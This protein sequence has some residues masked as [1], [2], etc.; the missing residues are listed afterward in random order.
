LADI[1]ISFPLL[2]D[3]VINPP[4]YFSVFGFKVYWYGVLLAAAII[5]AFIYCVKNAHK[6]GLTS[7][8]LFDML[9]ICVPTAVIGCRVYYVVFN[10]SLYQDNFWDIFKLRDGGIAMYG[11]IIFAAIALYIYSRFK[12]IPFGAVLDSVAVG[13]LIGHS[14]GRWGNFMNREAYGTVTDLPWK[15]GL[16]VNGTT[17][18][19]HPTFLYEAIWTFLGF[20]VLH[21]YSKSRKRAF[22]GQLFLMYIAW[23]GFGRFMIEGLRTDSLFLFGT[24]IRTSQA[25]GLTSCILSLVFLAI[26]YNRKKRV[27]CVLYVDQKNSV[28][29]TVEKAENSDIIN[30]EDDSEEIPLE[31]K[32][33]SETN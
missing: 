19:V 23:Y 6:V 3:L 5:C 12:K 11:G 9:I 25:L 28:A 26:I 17:T 13:L 16:A 20:I 10:W 4:R 15:M 27:P 14:I 24:A 32:D 30:N 22:D 1:P 33:D 21:F 18:Y 8:N 7:D 2:G 29:E 31:E